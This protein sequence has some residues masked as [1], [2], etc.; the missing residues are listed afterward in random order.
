MLHIACSNISGAVL[1]CEVRAKFTKLWSDPPG[2]GPLAIQLPGRHMGA[3]GPIVERH[4]G[5]LRSCFLMGARSA[6]TR[7][8]LSG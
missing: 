7:L 6:K 3:Q 4:A 8:S 2:D 5:A 1:S